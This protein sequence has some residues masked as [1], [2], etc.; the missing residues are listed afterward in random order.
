MSK[1]VLLLGAIILLV[2]GLTAHFCIAEAADS[3][4][5]KSG[6]L[7]VVSS[8]NNAGISVKGSFCLVGRTPATFCNL[9]AGR[10]YDIKIEKKGYESRRGIITLIP[11]SGG[12][13]ISSNRLNV[14]A[15]S[16]VVPGW[17]QYEYSRKSSGVQALLSSAASA[18]GVV[19]A[20]ADYADRRDD[21]RLYF[22]KY[23]DAVTIDE[24]KIA[25]NIMLEHAA[26]SNE[27]REHLFISAG[28]AG[29]LFASNLLE[30][31]LLSA[32]PGGVKTEEKGTLT[33]TT[34]RKSLRRALAR[35][36]VSPGL[37]QKY[38][39]HPIRGFLFQAAFLG[40]AFFAAESWEEYGMAGARY[41]SAVRA[42]KEASSA[43]E[44]TSARGRVAD[45]WS[46]KRDKER[47]R[48]AAILMAGSVWILNMLDIITGTEM[49][50]GKM[51]VNTSI[52]GKTVNSGIVYSF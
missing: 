27:A 32:P 18:A 35:S 39:D 17:G 28:I 5:E 9:F 14:I 48:N 47:V 10:S 42:L 30:T 40:A 26:L 46:I 31:V 25:Q 7:T 8:P 38:L 23:G 29:W 3:D 24:K 19:L 45:L 11:G 33:I 34:P 12:A 4:A 41:E 1:R 37:G 20:Y 15:K 21:Y 13:K 16:L 43:A 36:A 44:K 52:K 2:L 50:G 49:R 51:K 22:N 6:C